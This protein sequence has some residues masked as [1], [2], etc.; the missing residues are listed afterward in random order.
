MRV[1]EFGAVLKDIVLQLSVYE[2]ELPRNAKYRIP[3]PAPD[4]VLE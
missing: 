1:N 4:T 2:K 3:G